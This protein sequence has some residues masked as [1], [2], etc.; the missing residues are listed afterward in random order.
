MTATPGTSIEGAGLGGVLRLT[1]GA[2]HLA[3]V[4]EHSE[5]DEPAGVWTGLACFDHGLVLGADVD[6]AA[7]RRL[8]ARSDIADLAW[9]PPAELAAEHRQLCHAAIRAHLAGAREAGQRL[10]QQAQALWSLAWSANYQAL[11]LLQETGLARFAPVRPQRWVVASYEHHRGPHGLRQ[12]HIHNI[13]VT[14]LTTG[15]R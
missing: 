13:V 10:W 8:S 6:D 1:W 9:E 15:G 7:L 2:D 5:A 3:H 4:L 11:G 12:P 14:A